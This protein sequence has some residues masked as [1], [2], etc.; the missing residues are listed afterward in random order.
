M[1][2]LPSNRIAALD[3]LRGIAIL[4][5]VLS[6]ILPRAILP[7]WMY[8]AQV[9]PP[10]HVFD[11]TLPGITWVDL[12]FP[13]FLFSMG[14]AFPLA[15][16]PGL[17][18]GKSL[19]KMSFR[20]LKRGG[21][22]V[23][24][25]IMLQH[26]RPHHIQ[27]PPNAM[28]WGLAIVGFM[29]LILVYSE[30]PL[31]W[32]QER[33]W[34]RWLGWALLL[35][36]IPIYQLISPND[37]SLGRSDIILLV[38]ANMAIVAALLWL[39]STER[40]ELRV[41]VLLLYLALRLAHDHSEWMSSIWSW[42]PVDWF[43]RWDYLKYLFIVIP[44][45][46]AGELLLQAKQERSTERAGPVIFVSVLI[47]VITLVGLIGFQQRWLLASSVI[48]G[49]GTIFS[50]LSSRLLTFAHGKLLTW[51]AFL[52]LLGVFL[53]PF[54]GGIKKDPSTLSYY[55]L[56]AGL[57]FYSILL[58]RLWEDRISQFWLWKLVVDNGRN[59]MLAYVLMGNLIWP[60]LTLTGV[61]TLIGRL[62]GQAIP[63]VLVAFVKMLVLALLVQFITNRGWR[64]RT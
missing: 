21:L 40:P 31:Q 52:V 35:V 16:R 61:E 22:L 4:G 43:F 64:W 59:P 3:A 45:T 19:G 14:A 30:Y 41:G 27:N 60:V 44:G 36:W 32:M 15:M 7:A 62:H 9:A 10:Q 12:V 23:I 51:G 26:L 17:E 38:L 8:H 56:T 53:E 2:A 54:E 37:F 55:A 58:F 42:S 34:V 1:P 18:A 63:L 33:K 50:A 28:T 11:P 49:F 39:F 57:A 20:I 48:L 6:G 25:A 47:L 13:F 29:V 5:M 46:F 24:F